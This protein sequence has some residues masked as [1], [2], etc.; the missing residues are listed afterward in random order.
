[1][2]KRLCIGLCFLF[3]AG[4]VPAY[5]QNSIDVNR[6]LT[7]DS[8]N[9]PSPQM[10]ESIDRILAIVEDQAVTYREYVRTYGDT[11]IDRDRLEE[12]IDKE[13]IRQAGREAGVLLQREQ[14]QQFADSRIQEIYQQE[15]ESSFQRFLEARQMT[16]EEFRQSLI[17]R[18]RDQRLRSQVLIRFFPEVIRPDT[19]AAQQLVRGRLMIVDDK[20]T[21]DDIYQK[22]S[23]DPV[24]STWNRLFEEHAR[25]VPFVGE[26]GKVNWFRWGTY[27]AQI[28]YPFFKNDLFRLSSPFQI[29][30]DWGLAIPT[31]FRFQTTDDSTQESLRAFEQHRRRFFSE[32]LTDVLR[33]QYTVRIP[34]SVEQELDQDAG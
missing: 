8:Q 32:R 11:D 7:V 15:G 20:K 18:I 27:R 3:V 21:A 9:A 30:E 25:P 34:S 22:I 6:G 28:E 26:N 31:A 17:R 4:A 10:Q 33:E 1:M 19:Q 24:M 16:E 13:L 12:L 2:V 14:V 23:Q 5:A 29:G